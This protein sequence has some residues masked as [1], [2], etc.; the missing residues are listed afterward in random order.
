MTP[1]DTPNSGGGEE[2]VR[3]PADLDRPDPILAGLSPRQLATLILFGLA[4]WTLARLAEP[5]LG[6][7]M[8]A[9]V[10]AP[11]ALAGV[12]IGLGWR[13]GLSLDRLALAAVRWGWQPRRRVVA[14]DGLPPVPGWAGPPG[15]RLAALTGPVS[16]LGA[17]GVLELAGAGWALVC[18]AN[19][20]NLRL[21]SPAEQ[22]QLLASFARLLH[23]LDGPMQVLVRSQPA[24]LAPLAERLRGQAAGLVHPALERAARAHAG[25][26]EEVGGRYQA[27]HRELLVVFTQPPGVAGAAGALARQAERATVLL[28]AVG[29][30]L[31]PLDADAAGRVLAAATCPASPPRPAG[32]APAGAVITGR[33]P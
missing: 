19:P 11:V 6:L 24:D 14:P 8:A 9:V 26:L 20:V 12:G 31:T 23:A 21:R 25:W 28:A 5:L 10:A 29:V 7:P 22:Q 32:L 13:D 16:A 4:A 18:V 3:V 33:Q 27:R 17:D 30:T 15:P 2:R 1:T